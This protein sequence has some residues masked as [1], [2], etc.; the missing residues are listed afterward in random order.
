MTASPADSDSRTKHILNTAGLGLPQIPVSPQDSLIPVQGHDTMQHI[1]P[2]SEAG[3]NDI[4]CPQDIFP[5]FS[6]SSGKSVTS[7]R[8]YHRK[9]RL[10]A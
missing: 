6:E 4:A 1:S 10:S 5:L 8:K 2:V 3:K 7:L 9:Y